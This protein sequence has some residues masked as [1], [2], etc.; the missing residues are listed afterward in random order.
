MKSEMEGEF[1]KRMLTLRK[2]PFPGLDLEGI[3]NVDQ[4]HVEEIS[5]FMNSFRI[6]RV[7]MSV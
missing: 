6:R 7:A 2:V 5:T 3:R 4:V 1:K